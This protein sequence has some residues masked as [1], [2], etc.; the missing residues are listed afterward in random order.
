MILTVSAVIVFSVMVA[1]TGNVVYAPD[2]LL[3]NIA[4]EKIGYADNGPRGIFSYG[5]Y[6]NLRKG[7]YK[8]TIAY[9]TDTNTTFDMCYKDENGILLEMASGALEW[10]QNMKSIV[11]CNG[12][13][14]KNCTFE[15]RTYYSGTGYLQ[16]NCISVRQ[17]FCLDRYVVILFVSI[18]VSL[19][20]VCGRR[21]LR[22]WER[23][24][25]VLCFGCFYTV[26]A[27]V[28][29]YAMTF[30][31]GWQR[32]L[33]FGILSVLAVLH[34]YGSRRGLYD[35]D[36]VVRKLIHALQYVFLFYS[37]YQLDRVMR[38]IISQDARKLYADNTPYIFTCGII[39]GIVFI[40]ALIRKLWVRR[41][42][43]GIVYY[44]FV[45]LLAVQYIYYQIF[46]SFFS[47]KD[48]QLADEG[49]DYAGYVLGFM[50]GKFWLVFL[51]LI[52]IGVAGIILLKYTAAIDWKWEIAAGVVVGIVILYSHTIYTKDYGGWNSFENPNF[53][54]ETMN[55]RV[56]AFKLCGF[57]QYELRDL[58][59]TVLRDLEIDKEGT[60]EIVSFFENRKADGTNDKNSM[61]GI[62][63]G[64][65]VIFVLMESIDDTVC[66]EDVMPALYKMSRE[67]ISFSNMYASFYGTA[68]TINSETVTNIG[69]YAPLDGS[70]TYSFADNS[71]PHSLAS[72][73]TAAGYAARQFHF[74]KPGFYDRGTMNKTFGYQ[75]F[76]SLSKR[77][78]RNVNTELDTVF[79]EE[80][81]VYQAL[82]QDEKFFD[83]I[84]SYTAIR[85]MMRRIIW[86]GLRWRDI[87]NI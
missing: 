81:E 41:V 64:K 65:N 27:C 40:I 4:D 42:F 83:Y 32:A 26:V 49:S 16:V 70:M 37:L 76:V 48:M 24:G 67:G 78:D 39:A 86:F 13:D 51:S 73:F 75:E 63:K 11:I 34:A 59:K 22:M 36:A 1:I 38:G 9:D 71:F 54:Y 19:L 25:E 60:A 12:E 46:N 61:T 87:L 2:Q 68:P 33:A 17:C 35:S 23:P 43:Y 69:Y 53:I 50:N 84:T 8:I 82:V 45:V 72:R 6:I 58:K 18:I 85:H 3:Y 74:N 66:R 29:L 80:D 47:F 62:L 14:I 44:A 21:L 5:P 31:T 52:M 56:A 30:L 77:L 79:V 28:C 57:Y 55:N 15:V 20:L 7:N 10:N